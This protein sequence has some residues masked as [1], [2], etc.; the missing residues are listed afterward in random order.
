MALPPLVDSG[1][2]PEDMIPN[3]ASVEVP[4]EAPIEMLTTVRAA[5]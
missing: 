5:H 1:I 2:R 4:V 3:E